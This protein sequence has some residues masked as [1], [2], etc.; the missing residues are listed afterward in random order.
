MLDLSPLKNWNMATFPKIWTINSLIHFTF[1]KIYARTT[2]A[3][4]T[5][6]ELTNNVT[7]VRHRDRIRNLDAYD[8]D[9]FVFSSGWDWQGL[10]SYYENFEISVAMNRTPKSYFEVKQLYLFENKLSTLWKCKNE[11]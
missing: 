4:S 7:E 8:S 1:H 3:I 2:N 10:K 11:N 9:L 6:H 5:F